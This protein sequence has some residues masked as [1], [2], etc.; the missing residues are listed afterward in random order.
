[1][2]SRTCTPGAKRHW[3]VRGLNWTNTRG[4]ADLL[5]TFKQILCGEKLHSYLF[6]LPSAF[7]PSPS[8]AWQGQQDTLTNV[9]PFA[10]FHSVYRGIIRKAIAPRIQG[11][12]RPTVV[13]PWDSFSQSPG[14][15]SRPASANASR[16][17]L[18]PQGPLAFRGRRSRFKGTPPAK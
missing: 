11:R 7:P 5:T 2:N 18:T 16:C 13:D 8:T 12:C 10:A 9:T 1:M 6:W 4:Q 17:R 3:H 14:H 15:D